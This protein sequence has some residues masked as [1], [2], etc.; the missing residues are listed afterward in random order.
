MDQAK[1]GEIS[2]EVVEGKSLLTRKWGEIRLPKNLAFFLEE[3]DGV[4]F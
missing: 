4:N 1:G 3:E 2:E